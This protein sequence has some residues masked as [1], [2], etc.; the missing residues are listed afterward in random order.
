VFVMILGRRYLL[1]AL[2]SRLG[3]MRLQGDRDPRPKGHRSTASVELRAR[4]PPG[5]HQDCACST[6]KRSRRS[7]W[8]GDCDARNTWKGP[9][10]QIAKV[11]IEA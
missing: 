2:A 1:A 3:R 6:I 7:G 10:V 8:N 11:V 5:R 4:V 9:I